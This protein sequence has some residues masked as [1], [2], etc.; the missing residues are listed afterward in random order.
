VAG[1]EFRFEGVFD[2][3]S[4]QNDIYRRQEIQKA[5]K[6]AAEEATKRA[7]MA[8]WLLAYQQVE[9]EVQTGAAKKV[10]GKGPAAKP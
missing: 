4:V 2:P 3:V 10:A 7:E 6:A 9:K 1:T 5:K 8:D